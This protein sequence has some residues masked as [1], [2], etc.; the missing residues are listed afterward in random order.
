MA[1]N[2]MQDPM[3]GAMSADVLHNQRMADVMRMQALQPLQSVGASP[4]SQISPVQGLAQILGAHVA[5]KYQDKAHDAQTNMIQAMQTATEHGLQQYMQDYQ[6]DPRG[7]VMNAMK[8]PSPVVRAMATQEL[9]G[10]MTP[11]TM[12]SHAT[13]ASVI[14]SGG[15]VQGYAAKDTLTPIQPGSLLQD[16]Q[17]QLRIPT[18]QPGAAPVVTN[19]GGDLYHQTPT[20]LDLINKAPRTSVTVNNNIPQGETEFEKAFGR[21]EGAR[22]SEDLQ[23][24][25]GK[26]EGIQAAKDSLKL[27]DDGIHTGILADISKNLEKGYGAIASKEPEKAARTE[28]FIANVGNLVIPRLKDF[29]GSDTVEEMKYLQQVMGGNIKLEASSLR[30]ILNS[31]QKKL[32]ARV[33]ETDKTT[34]AYRGRGKTLP[35]IDSGVQQPAASAQPSGVMSAEDYLKQFAK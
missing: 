33:H 9:K 14:G 11:K 24:R 17:G 31:V 27:L 35:T 30:N 22:L 16:Q 15:N 28:Q 26:I 12:A 19:I 4:L 10:L 7:A 2:M 3:M 32:E 29:G 21:K 1:N 25:P 6:N 18:V 34:E 13:D 23:Q 5:N 8:S 20:G